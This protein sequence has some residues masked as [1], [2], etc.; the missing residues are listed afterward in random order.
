[1]AIIR[2]INV[3][4]T[5]DEQP[6]RAGEERLKW[7]QGERQFSGQPIE[8]P[9]RMEVPTSP[10]VEEI[11]RK[12]GG[13]EGRAIAECFRWSGSYREAERRQAGMA[14]ANALE[15]A[16][17][18]EDDTYF[19]LVGHSHGGSVIRYA[20]QYIDLPR[21]HHDRILSWNTVG[22]PFLH[23][24]R[25]MSFWNLSLSKMIAVLAGASFLLYVSGAFLD[26]R[27]R[28]QA[29]D[30]EMFEMPTRLCKV[31]EGYAPLA[32][33]SEHDVSFSVEDVLSADVKN[34]QVEVPEA[35]AVEPGVDEGE[36]MAE[37]LVQSPRSSQYIDPD[38]NKGFF[39]LGKNDVP[40][41]VAEQDQE[42]AQDK[43]E[44]IRAAFREFRTGLLLLALI[45]VGMIAVLVSTGRKADRAL[46][47]F[48]RTRRFKQV[49]LP[50]WNGFLNERD[51]AV[52]GLGL[53]AEKFSDK[54]QIIPHEALRPILFVGVLGVIF[55]S[56][57]GWEIGREDGAENNNPITAIVGSVQ[58]LLK[59]K[60]K[61]EG[62]FSQWLTETFDINRDVAALFDVPIEFGIGAL[63]LVALSS[64][65][66]SFPWTNIVR[67]MG[68]ARIV[69]S[70]RAILLGTDDIQG[71]SVFA[72][73]YFPRNGSPAQAIILPDD[74][75]QAQTDR[76]NGA[77][78]QTLEFIRKEIGLYGLNLGGDIPN[79]SDKVGQ[80]FTWDELYHTT[81][82]TV[83][84]QEL[85]HLGRVQDPGT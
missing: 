81:Y 47:N 58:D 26:V 79:L 1:M 69:R 6:A 62:F 25:P 24:R 15:A 70:I 59:I 46:Y 37:P 49:F 42:V 29:V 38:A 68:D 4:G 57:I 65:F 33:A 27:C 12:F 54:T 77:A 41:T 11:A 43:R 45:V 36:V 75:S 2:I 55:W 66:V 35:E 16:M 7:W 84:D 63:I 19:V 28:L 20:L 74:I 40:D 48:F 50:K 73:R 56:I 60:E 85:P 53:G 9:E 78:P 18:A 83:P 67:S 13:D 22:T 52:V 71:E 44:I 23:F 76:V 80:H 5:F 31:A 61:D 21:R 64:L 17:K 8:M 3:H 30:D 32:T 39:D 14:L 34:E 51:E 10:F 72:V 82:F